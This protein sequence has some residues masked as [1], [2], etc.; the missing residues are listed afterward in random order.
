MPIFD[1]V[2]GDVFDQ[3]LRCIAPE[4]RIAPIGFASGR[5]Q[6]IPANILLV[7]SVTSAAQ[8]GYYFGWS[9]KDVRYQYTDKLQAMMAQLCAWCEHGKIHPRTSHLLPLTQFK[10]AMKLVLGREA[11]AVS[12]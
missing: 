12:P 5:I 6:S 9:P 2:G 8:H 1:P 7:K 3:S 10:H 4:G 11:I